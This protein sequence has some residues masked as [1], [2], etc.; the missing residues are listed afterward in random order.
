MKAADLAVHFTPQPSDSR[1]PF[2]R[3]VTSILDWEHRDPQLH[4][5][6]NDAGVGG[7]AYFLIYSTTAP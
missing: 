5:Q 7:G 2:V 6:I 3:S 4:S 1:I